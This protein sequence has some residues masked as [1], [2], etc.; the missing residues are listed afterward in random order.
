VQE[1]TEQVSELKEQV[2][3]SSSDAAGKDSAL[4]SAR[5]QLEA[6]NRQLAAKKAEQD[7]L[8]AQLKEEVSWNRIHITF[9]ASDYVCVTQMCLF[10]PVHCHTTNE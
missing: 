6:A 5:Q 8:Q 2:S 9:P 7:Q 4:A 10:L 3:E 1:L